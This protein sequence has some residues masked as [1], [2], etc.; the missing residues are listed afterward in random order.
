MHYQETPSSSAMEYLRVLQALPWL[1]RNEILSN[2]TSGRTR[3]FFLREKLE[4]SSVC[5]S[6][7]NVT[8]VRARSIASIPPAVKLILSKAWIG[9]CAEGIRNGRRLV[10]HTFCWAKELMIL[11]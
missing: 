4:V 11:I 7:M 8:Q 5:T 1:Y 2:E 9:G 6:Q 10:S 3:T